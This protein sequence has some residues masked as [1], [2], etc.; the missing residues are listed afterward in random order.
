MFIRKLIADTNELVQNME[1]NILLNEQALEKIELIKGR[2]PETEND[3]E[4]KKEEWRANH[5]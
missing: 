5:S 4:D 1:K 3:S 2:V